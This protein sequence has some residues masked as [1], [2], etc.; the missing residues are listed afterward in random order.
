MRLED[1][2]VQDKADG[3]ELPKSKK[4]EL[5]VPVNSYKVKALLTTETAF[6]FLYRIV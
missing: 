4:Y 6:T 3:D 2:L 1:Q 5:K